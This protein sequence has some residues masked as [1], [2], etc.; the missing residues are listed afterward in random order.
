MALE[1]VTIGIFGPV[2]AGKSTFLNSILSDTMSS[3]NRKKTTML[4]QIYTFDSTK[5]PHTSKEI[6]ETNL[7]SNKQILELRESGKYSQADFTELS[8]NIKQVDDFIVLPDAHATY[9]IIDMPGLNCGDGDNMYYKYIDQNSHKID[10]YI[11]VFDINSGLNTTDEITILDFIANQIKKNGHGTVHV[12]INKCDDVDFSENKIKFE[13]DELND[14]YNR[15]CEI[16]SKHLANC[17]FSISPLSS[18]S[19]YVYRTIKTNI[20]SIEEKHLD[21]IIMNECGKSVLK[22]LGTI[23]LKR[24]YM[25][26]KLA[27]EGST[28]YSQGLIDTGYQ[29]FIKNLSELVNIRSYTNIVH[30][31][32]KQ[33]LK[34]IISGEITIDIISQSL[35]SI[36]QSL[37]RLS[38]I[39]ESYKTPADIIYL[40]DTI[41]Q[42]LN[43]YISSGINSYVSSHIDSFLNKM[44]N[45]MSSFKI[46]KSN[47]CESSVKLISDKR[48]EI[49]NNKLSTTYDAAIYTELVAANKLNDDL[50]QESLINSLKVTPTSPYAPENAYKLIESIPN[51]GLELT[52]KI[53]E[54]LTKTSPWIYHKGFGSCG[55]DFHFSFVHLLNFIPVHK[56]DIPKLLNVYLKNISNDQ[57]ISLGDLLF[58]K[59]NEVNKISLK[60]GYL[61]YFMYIHRT[62]F[63]ANQYVKSL[64]NYKE[65]NFTAN[66]LIE[67]L[68][69]VFGENSPPI[70]LDIGNKKTNCTEYNPDDDDSTI[71]TKAKQQAVA[72]A[73]E[74]LANCIDPPCAAAAAISNEYDDVSTDDSSESDETACRLATFGSK[75]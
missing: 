49:L 3:M 42:K 73:E 18:S 45:Y 70:V 74:T 63:G 59:L 31:H 64:N 55:K 20:E 9:S 14:L 39:N 47:D 11:L 1:H 75:L 6:F 65:L 34:N 23:D 46:I 15:C 33:Q 24:K 58:S 69:K 2:S 36:D 41:N 61:I 51:M 40:I 30:H 12:I 8:Y 16:T 44:R 25:R 22:S 7:K 56:V 19:L 43:T 71:Y 60:V 38:T 72:L 67:A 28:I 50:F 35:I 57:R 48:Y 32:I 53:T 4:P 13:E 29:L 27:A 10:I 62:N 68:L 54:L 52:V 21:K 17:Y 26:G 37:I 5:N 66:R